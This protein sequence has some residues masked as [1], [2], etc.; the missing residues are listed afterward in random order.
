MDDEKQK[1]KPP[2]CFLWLLVLLGCLIPLM[3]YLLFGTPM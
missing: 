1:Q 3:L 2:G